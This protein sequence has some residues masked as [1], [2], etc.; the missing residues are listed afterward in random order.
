MGE[1]RKTKIVQTGHTKNLESVCAVLKN[2]KSKFFVKR[3]NLSRDFAP[4]YIP[5]TGIVAKNRS[6]SCQNM[7]I[8]RHKLTN[9][10]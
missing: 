2:L 7:Y 6:I 1:S 9:L 10:I 5:Y 3:N 4:K 8:F